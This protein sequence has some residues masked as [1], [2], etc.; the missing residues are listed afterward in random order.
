MSQL[1]GS[2]APRIRSR[3]LS[4]ISFVTSILLITIGNGCGKPPGTVSNKG[5]ETNGEKLQPWKVAAKALRKQSDF[6][7]CRVALGKL[8]NDLSGD[9]AS[10]RPRGL[11]EAEEEALAKLVPLAKDDREEIRPA[12]FSTHDGAYLA[13]CLYLRDA[14]RS[15]DIPVV[16]DEKPEAAAARRADAAF[17]WTCRQVYLNPWLIPVPGAPGAEQATTL[18]PTAVLR[19]GYGSGLERMYVFLGLLQQLGLDGCLVGPPEASDQYAG[20]VA[21]SP[22]KKPLTNAPRGPFWACG[23]RVGNDVRLYDP[24]RGQ[25]FPTPL[26]ELKKNPEAHRTW[27]EDK[28]NVSGITAELAKTA[29]VFLAVPVNALAPRMIALEQQLQHDIGVKLAIDPAKLRDSF[30]EPK[31][32][33]WN[34]I[35]VDPRTK[36]VDGDRFAYGR[37]A[38]LFLPVDQGG[39]DEPEGTNSLYGAYRAAQLPPPGQFLPQELLNREAV[40]EDVGL[41][42]VGRAWGSY[43]LAFLDSPTPRERLQRGQFQDASRVLVERQDLFRRGQERLRNNSGSDKLIKEWLDIAA[44]LYNEL[45]LALVRGDRDGETRARAAIDNLWIKHPGAQALVDRA[46]SPVGLAEATLLLAQCKH[47]QAE[48]LQMQCELG[49]GDVAKLRRDAADAWAEARGAWNSYTQFTAAHVAF[50]GRTAHADVLARRAREMAE[51]IPIK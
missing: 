13:D 21:Y 39:T 28:A 51:K 40:R 48:R 24:W 36:S 31:P 27:F 18:P 19:R 7:A 6:D 12:N 1:A 11:S 10:P 26:S 3:I 33:F 2:R 47:E 43:T 14:A 34:P 38:R 17:A 9:P 45:G 29:T 25:S 20:F 42:I 46:V 4:V 15:F 16:A 32:A 5:E 35:I 22:D 37:N 23:V 49:V 8:N 44:Q 41:Q 30:P 50:P